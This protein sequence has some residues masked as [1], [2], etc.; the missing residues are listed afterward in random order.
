MTN[1][2]VNSVDSLDLRRERQHIREIDKQIIANESVYRN[3]KPK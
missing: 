3:C 2:T 1:F